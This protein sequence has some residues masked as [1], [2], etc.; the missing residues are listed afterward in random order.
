MNIKAAPYNRV[1][2]RDRN[3]DPHVPVPT[4]TH[5]GVG[6]NGKDLV[7][8]DMV[9]TENLSVGTS[10]NIVAPNKA[11]IPMNVCTSI[12]FWVY[13]GSS[14]EGKSERHR[15]KKNPTMNYE[16][17]SSMAAPHGRDGSVCGLDV[18]PNGNVACSLSQE[19]NAFRVWVKNTASAEVLWKCLYKVKTPSGFSNMLSAKKALSSSERL[20]S[21]SSDGSVLSVCYGSVVTLW[22]HSNATLLTSLATND[23]AVGSQ[24]TED[25]QEIYFIN[26]SDDTML[27]TTKTQV[28]VK[29]PFGGCGSKCY[30]GN[31][32]W[33]FSSDTLGEGKGTL[34][35][36]T[37]LPGFGGSRGSGGFFVTSVSVEDGKK[38]IISII[39]REKGELLR[40]NTKNDTP[41]RWEVDG[42]VQTICM[43]SCRGSSLHLLAITKDCNMMS[44]N[45]ETEGQDMV[46]ST[47][48]PIK[49]TVETQSTAPLLKFTAEEKEPPMKKRKITIRLNRRLEKKD[50]SGF[51]FPA[52]SGRF[53]RAFIAGK[54]NN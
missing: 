28:Y 3:N 37:T 53:T 21:F 43:S 16:L 38:S 2:R 25:I 46:T 35:A 15:K 14:T 40:L 41:T 22:D 5:M 45:I 12:K 33:T 32:E 27:L 24:P 39:N 4:V 13:R 48:T 7:T 49:K 19:E 54:L 6:K 29:S 51:D 1:S 30:L 18:A 20:V 11:I 31:D 50:Y 8:V 10:R 34:S 23:N 44:L 9:W 42:E 36:V 17:V 47:P 26:K 52:L